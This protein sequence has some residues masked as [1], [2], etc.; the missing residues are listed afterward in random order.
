MSGRKKVESPGRPPRA[1]RPVGGGEVPL[2]W[3]AAVGLAAFVLYLLLA[4]AVGGE[5]DSNELTLAL[6]VGGIPHPT[7]YPLYILLGGLFCS[8][9]HAVGTGWWL[10][11]NAWSALG[12]GMALF[13]LHALA[14]RLA[15]QAAPLAPQ[16]ASLVALVPVLV[17]VFNPVWVVEATLAEVNSWHAA[18]VAGACLAA[19]HL[20]RRLRGDAPARPGRAG[21]LWGLVC[22]LGLAHHLT[23]VLFIVP[24]SAGVLWALWRGRRPAA[25]FL[26]AAAAGALVPL[27]SY[28]YVFYRAF[29][30]AAFQWPLLE[31]SAASVLA[32]IRGGQFGMLIGHFAPSEAQQAQM[33]TTIY[34]FLFPGL[35]LLLL[36]SLRVRGAAE[37][38]F[39]LVIAVAALFQGVFVLNYGAIDPGTYFL[40]PLLVALLAL[41]LWGAP[42]AARRALAPAAGLVTLA[43]VAALAVSWSGSVAARHR[44]LLGVERLVRAA[45]ESVPFERGVLFWRNDMYAR[46]RAYQLLDGEKTDLYVENPGMLTWPPAR[47]AFEERFG[48]DA[49][50][51][52]ELESDADLARV[53]DNVGRQ[54]RMP[55]ADFD[56]LLRI[57]AERSGPVR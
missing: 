34:P 51:G 48:F 40:A 41:A 7:G 32:H 38:A 2:L 36:G 33:E 31:P 3:S 44:R 43:A 25:G 37:R 13:F 53:A 54:T 50:S 20:M 12:A 1:E 24:L 27:A 16:P 10:A 26:A 47:A 52:L 11:A 5:G 14:A 22:G 19:L 49:L 30:P 45:W 56:E 15:R 9:L 18:W 39:V 46:L 17:L 55:V 35:V 6:A 28:A 29:H 4:P 42:V 23:S 8:A 21:F 57:A